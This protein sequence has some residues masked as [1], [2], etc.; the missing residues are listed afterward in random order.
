VPGPL[1]LVALVVWLVMS[2]RDDSQARG[3]TAPPPPGVPNAGPDAVTPAQRWAADA[4]SPD[5]PV[6][7]QPTPDAVGYEPPS[8]ASYEQSHQPP[9]PPTF[10]TQYVR[11]LPR[12]PRKRGPKLFWFTMALAALAVGTVGIVDVSGADVAGSTYPAV[13]T[14]VIA[15]MLLVGAFYGRAG[16]LILAGLLAAGGT[17]IGLASEEVDA[18]STVILP[19]SASDVLSTYDFAWG[20]YTL[21]LSRLSDPEALDGRTISVTGE[22]GELVVVIPS[23]VDVA[24]DGRIDG[25]GGYT[26][27]GQESGGIDTDYSQNFDA[28][29]GVPELNLDLQLD[30]GHIEVRTQP[31]REN[32]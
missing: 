5:V 25:P 24:V 29:T 23:G 28:G 14:G 2:R 18:D 27:F 3:A 26:F 32:R 20:S 30:M 15:V 17:G 4:P 6:E 22:V 31:F 1:I 16:G 10:A 12:N 7:Q 19:R 13:V 11:P 8:Y 21:D 9:E